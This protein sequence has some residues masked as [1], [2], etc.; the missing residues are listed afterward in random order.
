MALADDDEES[1]LRSVALQ[2]ASSILRARQRAEQE[3]LA[4]QKELRDAAERLQLALS[5]GRLGDWSWDASS[6]IVRLS[7]RAAEIFG[8]PAETQVTWAQLW[9]LPHADDLQRACAAVENA[10]AKRSDYAI[11]YRVP[12]ASGKQRWI[13]VHGRGTYGESGSV[14]RMAGVVEDITERKRLLES[15]RAARAA[16]EH[17]SEMKDDFLAT[18][19][20]ELR[21][22]LTAILG[23]S[24][25]LRRRVHDDTDLQQG[26]DAIERNARMQ[27]QLIEDLLDM[28]RIT[29][30]KVRLDIQPVE[31]M[32]FVE[33]AIETVRPAADAKGIRLTKTLDP[34]AGP[35]SA[36][37][38]RL[39]QIVWN[40]LANAIK[41][42]PREGKVQVSL[43]RVNSHIEIR[44][45]DTGVGIGAEF[46]PHVF[47]RFRQA[48]ATTTR[49]HGGLGLGLS[50]VKTL[51]ELHGGTVS[52][53]SEGEG[54]GATFRV[55]IPVTVLHSASQ[56]VPRSHPRA[57]SSSPQDVKMVD[58]SGLK[59]LVVDDEPDA[60]E[61]IKRVLA[62]CQAEVIT[63][64]NAVDALERV[65]GDRPHVLVSDIGMPGVDGYEL[66]KR[67]RALGESGGGRLP[68][69][70]LTAFAR[71]E[72]RTRALRAGFQIHVAKPV[73]P[74]ELIATVA[75]VAGRTGT[76]SE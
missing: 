23:W 57:A 63:A 50:I 68:A 48:N 31:P 11:E 67:I 19:S 12:L 36:D 5:A 7:E 44:I 20:H 28:S 74:S 21:T 30:G 10:L 70:A 54:C 43:E 4:A 73:E 2:N 40:L 75:M 62:E 51:V 27:S 76:P 69:I 13:E 52:A 38:G 6:D 22:P 53:H 16:A 60:R 66:L 26:L 45:T 41:F 33:A 3:L 49:M 56:E 1:L 15:E 58:L 35:I 59:V 34:S 32:T 14:V 9:K 25:L 8:L 47:E 42:T 61:L 55:M 65:R 72:D 71:S 24:N 18:L 29:S 64:G 39:Q 37:P 17:M 46:L